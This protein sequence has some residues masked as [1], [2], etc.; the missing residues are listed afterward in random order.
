MLGNVYIEGNCFPMLTTSLLYPKESFTS[1]F[2]TARKKIFQGSNFQL[3]PSLLAYKFQAAV[4]SFTP[5]HVWGD[6]Q[7]D[8]Y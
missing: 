8:S 6:V 5:T 2:K 3:I 4:S 7:H 1:N